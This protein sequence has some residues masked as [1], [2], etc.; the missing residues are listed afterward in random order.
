MHARTI[1][2]RFALM[3][4]AMATIAAC[5]AIRTASA[6]STQWNKQETLGIC[7]PTTVTGEFPPNISSAGAQW[8]STN[9]YLPSSNYLASATFNTCT[10]D[11]INNPNISITY[12]A[13]IVNTATGAIVPPG[14]TVPFGAHLKVEFTPHLSQDVNWFGTGGSNDTPY[15]DWVAAAGAPGPITCADKDYMQTV[16]MVY[17]GATSTY[18]IK[19][20]ADLDV[21][22]PVKTFAG[23]GGMTCTINGASADCTASSQGLQ[24]IVF[25]F[26]PTTGK[27]Y[28][29]IF[30]P[31]FF[32]V[33]YPGKNGSG[34]ASDVSAVLQNCVGNNQPMWLTNGQ[35]LQTS[36]TAYV[37]QVPVQSIPYPINVSAPDLP[38]AAPTVT[39]GSCTTGVQTTITM[40]TTDPENNQIKYGIDWDADGVVDQ[41]V[42]PSGYVASGMAQTATRTY[43]TTGSKTIKVLAADDQGAQSTW[44]TT[45]FACNAPPSCSNGLDINTYPSC[46]CPV[47]KVQQGSLCVTP[48]CS[49]GLDINT[50]PSCTCPSGQ[51]QSGTTCIVPSCPAGQTWNGTSCVQTSC[52][53]GLNFTTYPS[54]TCPSGYIQNGTICVV[55][56]STCSN[57]LDITKYPSCSCPSGYVQNGNLCVQQSSTCSNGLDIT[58]YPSCACPSGQTQSGTT[59]VASSCAN[60]LSITQYPSC[61]CPSGYVQSGTACVQQSSTCSNGLDMTKY[62]SC[63]CPSGQV[64]N[65]STCMLNPCASNQTWN[66]TVCVNVSCTNGL[67][68]TLYPSCTCP[69][70]FVQSGS[71]CVCPAGYTLSGSQCVPQCAVMNFCQG[72]ALYHQYAD[73][74]TQFMQTCSYSCSAGACQ[75]APAPTGTLT[76]T[77]SLVAQ[78]ST[79]QIKWSTTNV[80][81]TSC[82]VTGNGNSWSGTSGTQTSAPIQ[83]QVTYTLTCRGLDGS[84][85]TV[86]TTVNIIPT[87]CE[88]GVPGC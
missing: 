1:T 79:S 57:G 33:L 56:S 88:P 64:Q 81:A 21:D 10:V 51:T 66:G 62:P 29:R 36:G 52:A 69:S 42:P 85:L 46:S 6:A 19:S 67:D 41:W 60:G 55:Q 44:T 13:D 68:V 74:S 80:V 47:G 39:A 38:P 7:I 43:S 30:F 24:N 53:N 31:P 73:C 71:T 58:K 12:H 45:T 20:Y 11:S 22:P 25:N 48:T 34:G 8:N 9:L 77:P 70:T 23:L 63:A 14:G 18:T 83:G 32:D 65:G 75:A 72:S 87:F 26:A 86:T 17:Y 27:F 3:I 50:Y 76:A 35:L 2:L 16:P 40:Q 49:N 28:G 59:C 54:C 4:G 61:T 15:G 78:G 5:S 84:T 37:L 82:T